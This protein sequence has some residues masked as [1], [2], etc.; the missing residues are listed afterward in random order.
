MAPSHP[1]APLSW[2]SGI[3][4]DQ[5]ENDQTD[6]CEFQSPVPSDS[7][8][9][10][11]QAGHSPDYSGSYTVCTI[12]KCWVAELSC[13]EFGWLCHCST[14]SGYT[15]RSR[16]SHPHEPPKPLQSSACSTPWA[17]RLDQVQGKKGIRLY[18]PDSIFMSWKLLMDFAGDIYVIGETGWHGAHLKANCQS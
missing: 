10:S 3:T 4:K 18:Y 1:Q 17:V 9:W 12:L 2:A 14:P 11:L 7:I 16:V 8:L 6:G 13:F 5:P 15:Q